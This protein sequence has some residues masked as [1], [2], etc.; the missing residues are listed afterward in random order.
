MPNADQIA[1]A[2]S[3]RIQGRVVD[4]G[5][6][7][8]LG[9]V[10]IDNGRIS[11][12]PTVVVVA[13]GRADVA[14]TVKFAADEGI[15]LTARCGGHGASGYCLN[16]SGIVLDLRLL[17]EKAL[18]GNGVLTLGMGNV[19]RSVYDYLETSQTELI[20]IGGGC[21]DVGVAGFLLGGG[22]S[23]VSRS[24][25]LG[26]DNVLSLTVVKA[27]GT[28][29]Q[30]DRKNNP[31]LFWAMRGGGGGNF[32]IAVE[33]QLQVQRPR[34]QSMLMGQV[35]FPFYR[36]EEVLTAYNEWEEGLPN[37]MAVY[38]FLGYQPDPRN[39]TR[40]ILTVRFTPVYN[41][42]FAEGVA[43]LKPL[44]EL[45]PIR[46]DLLEMTIPEWEDF[47]GAGTQVRGRSAYIRSIVAPPRSLSADV[48]RVFMKHMT[49]APSLNSFVVWTHLGGA[50]EGPFGDED[51][52]FAHRT[53]RF[54]PEVK[55]IWDSAK[56]QEMRRN[57][58]WVYHFFEDLTA[59]TDATGAYLNYID[60]LL[61]DWA[62]KYYGKN[63]DRLKRIKQK[64]DPQDLFGFQQGIGSTYEPKPAENGWL[65]LSPLGRTFV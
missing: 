51:G 57:V 22:F 40:P 18:D 37:E 52:S 11:H 1:R 43:L 56:P 17:N 36:L 48:A 41:G 32:A 16:S 50:V 19:W 46:A 26:S 12:E 55:S 54:V 28:V 15:P 38:G 47:I 64:E 34:S 9:A 62:K 13:A 30:I 58:E 3:P 39:P 63:Y 53:G 45:N 24:Y 27:D 35:F 29:E 8:Y 4:A 14:A 61:V 44:F 31:D 25:G 6:E 10:Q 49:R 59:A 21:P 33:A 60:P 65:D 5:D 20:P 23:F 2:L 7:E 42:P